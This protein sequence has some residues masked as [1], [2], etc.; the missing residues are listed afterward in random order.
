MPLVKIDV[1]TG[2]SAEEVRVLLDSVQSAVI[3]A[4]GVPETDRYQVLTQHGPGEL[5]ALDTGLGIDR[6]AALVMIHVIS[7][8]RPAEAKQELYR[9]LAHNLERDCALSPDDLVVAISDNGDADWSFG[10]GRAQFVT[11]ELPA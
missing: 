4:F 5:V 6:S 8:Q 2:R 11:G 1:N 3:A 7:K 10:Q 9:L